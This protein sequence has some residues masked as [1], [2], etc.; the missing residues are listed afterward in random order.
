MFAWDLDKDT[1]YEFRKYL[2]TII[3]LRKISK[4][5]HIINKQLRYIPYTNKI[6]NYEDGTHTRYSLESLRLNK[7]RWWW[8]ENII[9]RLPKSLGTINSP[10]VV[11]ELKI[12]INKIH[13]SGFK[14]RLNIAKEEWRFDDH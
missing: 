8:R 1:H 3:S 11:P 6:N 14:N 10:S 12:S 7:K 9:V 5:I 4:N 13:E 2:N